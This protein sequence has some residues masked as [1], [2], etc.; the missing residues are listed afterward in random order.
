MMD[1][2]LSYYIQMLKSS[3]VYKTARFA[4]QRHHGQ[5]L[6]TT[7]IQKSKSHSLTPV[8]CLTKYIPRPSCILFGL[9]LAK[10]CFVGLKPPPVNCLVTGVPESPIPV[11]CLA[12]VVVIGAG[13]GGGTRISLGKSIEHSRHQTP[14]FPSPLALLSRLFP[15]PGVLLSFSLS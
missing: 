5:H 7:S 3:T 9:C 4:I 12:I 2:S 6:Y 8:I 14:P 15:H 11:N 10:S 13:A 1:H